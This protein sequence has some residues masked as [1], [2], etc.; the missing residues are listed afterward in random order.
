[1][2]TTGCLVWI[3]LLLYWQRQQRTLAVTRMGPHSHG[4][5]IGGLASGVFCSARSMTS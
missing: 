4:P 1:M 2:R 5:A 3:V